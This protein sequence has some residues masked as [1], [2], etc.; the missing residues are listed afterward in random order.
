MNKDTI[1][2]CAITGAGNPGKHPDFPITPEQIARSAIEAGEAGAAIAHVH[3]RNP[4]TGAPSRDLALYREVVER[5]RDSDSD[6]VINITAG[7]G[8]DFVP[9]E[10]N[11]GVGGEGTDMIDAAGRIAHIE[12]LQ[13]EICTLDCGSINFGDDYV[14]I[15][16]PPILREMAARVKAIGVKPELEVFELGHL[17]FASQ[18]HADGLLEAPA[19][20]QLCLGIPWGAPANTTAMKAMVDLLPESCNWAGFGIGRL[21]M[22][23]VA[24]ATLLGGNVRVGL[25]D[26]LYL[27]KGVFAS[28]GQLVEKAA[29]IIRAMGGTIATPQRARDILGL[30]GTQ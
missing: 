29:G 27:E 15:S 17:A 11:P 24:Q 5:I 8:G 14:Y 19:L 10:D 3:V 30:R 20:F 13:P 6:I 7:M 4:D 16:T 18:M 22:P 25:E 28:N 21:Q 26:N 12:E 2:T 9:D 1:I 23:M